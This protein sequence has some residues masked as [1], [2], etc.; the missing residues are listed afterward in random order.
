MNQFVVALP[1]L[2]CSIGMGLMMW[3]M[4]RGGRKQGSSA[5]DGAGEVARLRAEI[6]SLQIH[7]EGAAQS[8]APAPARQS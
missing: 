4:I 6:A 2:G 8:M 7:H 1:L 3:F 5:P